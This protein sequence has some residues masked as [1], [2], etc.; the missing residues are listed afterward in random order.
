[1]PKDLAEGVLQARVSI[2]HAHSF[3]LLAGLSELADRY[4]ELS[5][6]LNDLYD[7]LMDDEPNKSDKVIKIRDSFNSI[8]TKIPGLITRAYDIIYS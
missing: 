6:G 1:M 7:L 3:A 8:Q 4:D 5:S 2:N